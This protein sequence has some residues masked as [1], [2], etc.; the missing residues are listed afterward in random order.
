MNM[1]LL[2]L[3]EGPKYTKPRR[4]KREVIPCCNFNKEAKP[5][6]LSKNHEDD[7]KISSLGIEFMTHTRGF[8]RITSE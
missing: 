1:F 7:K 8:I 2:S 6:C 3:D 4:N 5:S